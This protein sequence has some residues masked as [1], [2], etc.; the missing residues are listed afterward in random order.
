PAPLPATPP[1]PPTTTL[2]DTQPHTSPSSRHPAPPPQP[3][4]TTQPHHTP[5][6]TAL[7]AILTDLYT[8]LLHQPHINT[9]DNFFTLGGN[10]LQIMQIAA[11][12]HHELHLDI[13]IT[14]FFLNPTPAQLATTLRDR[15]G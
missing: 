8:R 2:L 5:P 7:E 4:P 9:T 1:F 10:S 12:L 13:P 6:H 11:W 14:T 15:Y 3:P